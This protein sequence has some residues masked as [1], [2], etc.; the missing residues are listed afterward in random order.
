MKA[1]RWLAILVGFLSVAG[2]QGQAPPTEVEGVYSDDVFEVGSSFVLYRDGRFAWSYSYGALDLVGEGRWTRESET[3]LRLDSDPP[4]VPPRFEV[5]R[6]ERDGRPGILVRLDDES[7]SAATFLFAEAEYADGSRARELLGE[8]GH[9]FDSPPSRLVTAVLLGSLPLDL[10]SEAFPV[11]PDE[12][13]V[14]TFRFVPN[15]IGR[16]DFQGQA[17]RVEPGRL[18]FTWRGQELRY[19]REGPPPESGPAVAAPLEEPPVAPGV[20]RGRVQVRL[21]EPVAEM[22]A[23]STYALVASTPADLERGTRGPVDLRVRIGERDYDAGRVGGTGLPVV[24]I[25]VSGESR[26]VESVMFDPQDRLLALGEALARAREVRSWLEQASAAAPSPARR[27]AQLIPAFSVIGP[28]GRPGA[29]ASGWEAAA[30]MLAAEAA[31]IRSMHLYEL[32]VADDTVFVMIENV[33]RLAAETCTRAGVDCSGGREWAVHVAIFRDSLLGESLAP[34]SDDSMPED[35]AEEPVV[36]EP[37]VEE[38][39]Q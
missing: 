20:S 35:I 13:N 37:P 14:L 7:L 30:A 21:G 29:T 31:A 34:M 10:R 4:V 27:E 32:L 23:R 33:R 1:A 2:A 28:D 17:V 38:T 24:V 3:S 22:E 8:E 39:P 16:A 9:R 12:A 15:D 19:V 6:A 25:G 26:R 36:E 11:S 18:S 5:A